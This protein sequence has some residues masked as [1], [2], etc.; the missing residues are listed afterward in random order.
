MNGTVTADCVNNVNCNDGLFTQ[1]ATLPVSAAFSCTWIDRMTANCD[2]IQGTQTRIVIDFEFDPFLG[3]VTKLCIGEATRT[4]TVDFPTFVHDGAFS[5]NPPTFATLRSRNIL[6]T[7]GQVLT[8]Q[9]NAI[10]VADV[11]DEWLDWVGNCNAA[12]YE[13]NGTLDLDTS[14][15]T[16]AINGIQYDLDADANEIPSW[17]IQND[18]HDLIYIAYAS[19]ETLPGDTTDVAPADGNPD[20][21][22]SAGVD[23]LNVTV[24]GTVN[25]N[26]RA[27]ILSV[28][29]DLTGNRPTNLPTDYLD[30]VENTDND[31]VFTKSALSAGYND[32]TRIIS[33]LLN[34]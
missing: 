20:N 12:D 1:I 14:T 26:I 17:I 18:W 31:D 30:N 6:L 13:G 10:T 7:V 22:C 3:I 9:L 8:D 15:G 16:L 19:G 27:I 23:C 2:A 24:N 5:Q 34:P 33:T 25:N 4:I 11:Y 28:G 32:Q 29:Q 21:T